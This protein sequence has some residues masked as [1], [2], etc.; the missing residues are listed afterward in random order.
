MKVRV[1]ELG[2]KLRKLCDLCFQ[3]IINR[4]ESAIYHKDCQRAL[5]KLRMLHRAKDGTLWRTRW[6]DQ[7]IKDLRTTMKEKHQLLFG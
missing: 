4:V 6:L 1:K 3:P 2:G 7:T 5:V